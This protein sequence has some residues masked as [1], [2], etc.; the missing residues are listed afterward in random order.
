MTPEQF[1]RISELYQ[2]AMEL[3][4]ETRPDFLTAACTGDG[5]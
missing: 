3:A 4:P 5:Q 2:A 1:Q